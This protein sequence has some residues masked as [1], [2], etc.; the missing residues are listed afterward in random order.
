MKTATTDDLLKRN[1]EYA[2]KSRRP[3]VPRLGLR[4]L[5][6]LGLALLFGAP[7]RI[8]RLWLWSAPGII[9]I[10]VY[11]VWLAT[12]GSIPVFLVLYI[13]MWMAL[14]R[15]RLRMAVRLA[16]LMALLGVA[17]LPFNPGGIVYVMYATW[18]APFLFPPLQAFIYV[19][20]LIALPVVAAF[21]PFGVSTTRQI[22]FT[23]LILLTGVVSVMYNLY[24]RQDIKLFF[25]QEEVEEMAALAE[26]ERIS[27]DL[28]DL[29]GHT[30]SV[31]A[32]KSELASRIADEDPRRAVSEIRDVE[33]V[34]RSALAEV[35]AA[36]EGYRGLG[37]S[38]E[39]RSAARALESA[40]ISL[41]ARIAD[42]R[43]S[44]QHESVLALAVREAL[45]NVV[46]HSRATA[47]RVALSRSG[48]LVV[49]T[50][51]DNGTAG[52]VSEGMGL[53]GMRERVKA[54]GGT[55]DIA[56]DRGLTVT[57]SLPTSTDQ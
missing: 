50:V 40:G 2:L 1:R 21:I 35:R 42:F 32:L 46:R 15:R 56:T 13:A 10:E 28:H 51:S 22:Q 6:P 5:L 55:V 57:V 14:S 12:L 30:L 39:L 36:V 47:C 44:P 31:I 20:G 53:A 54:A 19:A 23:P 25:A 3:D 11:R 43:M 52:T 34:S 37:L 8:H 24:R 49:L 29:L 48:G 7:I 4:L 16:G 9:P 41:D 17:L 45:T 38:G 26:R 33:Q 27:R 18:F